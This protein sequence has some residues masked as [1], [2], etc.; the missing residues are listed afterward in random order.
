MPKLEVFD[1]ALCCSTGVCGV[2]VDPALAQFAA[3]L[4]WLEAHGVTVERYNLGQNPAAFATNPRV[5]ALLQ[6][7]NDRLPAVFLDGELLASGAYPDR[8]ALAAKLGLT[9]VSATDAPASGTCCAAQPAAGQGKS[10]C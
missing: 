4:K 2:D 7:G 10:C 9:D 6:Q 3:D 8:H 5:L 1:P